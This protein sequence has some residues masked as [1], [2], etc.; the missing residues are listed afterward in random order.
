MPIG[1]NGNGVTFECGIKCTYFRERGYG[2][3]T[4]RQPW[5]GRHRISGDSAAVRQKGLWGG[6]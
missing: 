5:T 4:L 3:T 1:V 6:P 2:E